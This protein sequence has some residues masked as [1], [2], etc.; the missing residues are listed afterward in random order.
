[1]LVTNN[2]LIYIISYE[3]SLSRCLTGQIVKGEKI[4]EHL[5]HEKVEKI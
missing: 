3:T 4:W 1:M 5:C 2:I